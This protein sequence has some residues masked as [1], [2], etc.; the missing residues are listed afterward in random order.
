M[1]SLDLASLVGMP[2][3]WASQG[4]VE[5]L[6][7]V[8]AVFVL[9]RAAARGGE[10]PA[11]DGFARGAA[12]VLFAAAGTLLLV[13]A[14]SV[15][16]PGNPRVRALAPL[17][18]PLVL[19]SQLTRGERTTRALRERVREAVI[20]AL[21]FAIVAPA[22]ALA[23]FV[24][25]LEGAALVIPSGS[26]GVALAFAGALALARATRM[27]P[28][29]TLA[30]GV[31]LGSQ[32]AWLRT[33]GFPGLGARLRRWEDAWRRLAER[34]GERSHRV[35]VALASPAASF[36]IDWLRPSVQLVV[37]RSGALRVAPAM[38]APE[39]VEA[40]LAAPEGVLAAREL[41]PYLVGAADVHGAL[42]SLELRNAA[43]AALLRDDESKEIVGVLYALGPDRDALTETE[44]RALRRLA[45][46][47][48]ASI[49][50]GSEPVIAAR[51]KGA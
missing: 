30:G 33:L 29:L 24:V 1:L 34:G 43:A 5:A 7:A 22:L 42:R 12:F 10:R 44:A 20:V 32:L 9:L 39:L 37:D 31:A 45:D 16:L 3:P 23:P 40:L 38:P 19:A 21:A 49:G 35:A 25:L 18:S 27:A 6:L 51:L 4:V 47:V 17:L 14:G 41:H 15:V 8:L 28:E 11:R 46:V 50:A 26:G 2:E 36:V 48:A 13:R